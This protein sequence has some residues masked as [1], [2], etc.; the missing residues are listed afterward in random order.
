MR[1]RTHHL[2]SRLPMRKR[3]A[4]VMLLVLVCGGALSWPK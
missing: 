3:I 2:L 4:L 1:T